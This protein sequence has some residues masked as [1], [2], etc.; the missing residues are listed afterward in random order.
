[1]PAMVFNTGTQTDLTNMKQEAVL[2]VLIEAGREVDAV[3]IEVF[4]FLYK[5]MRLLRLL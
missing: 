1:M 3:T 4:F 2:K 5:C